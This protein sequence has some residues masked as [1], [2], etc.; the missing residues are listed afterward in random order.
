MVVTKF[1]ACNCYSTGSSSV[2]CSSSAQCSCK[3]G[4]TGK[5]CSSCSSGY[6]KS[7]FDCS[8]E[9]CLLIIV[10]LYLHTKYNIAVYYQILSL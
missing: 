2:S 3:T 9:I 4:Y 6:Y 7:G 10:L 5:T 1:S 8:G